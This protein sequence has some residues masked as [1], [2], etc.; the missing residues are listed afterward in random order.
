MVSALRDDGSRRMAE[1]NKERQNFPKGRT[2]VAEIAKAF[3]FGPYRLI[4][5]RRTLAADGR[6]VPIRGRAFDLL[7]ALV[8]RR[9][10]AVSKDELMD[11]VWPGRIVEKGNL[12]VHVAALR[13]F[14]GSGIIATLS[15]RGY[16]FVAP[17]A[18]VTV[19][20]P[21]QP[22]L[23]ASP[24][25]PP[26]AKMP[27]TTGTAPWPGD[28]PRPLTKLIGRDGDIDRVEARL[29]QGRL[30][31]VVGAGGVG[32]T[33]LALAA[34]DRAWHFYPDGVW[35]ADLGRVEDP[36]LVMATI[37]STLGIDTGG[38]EVLRAVVTWLAARRGLLVLD[39]CEHLLCAAADAT[40]A[41]LRSCP[42]I[43]V[44]AT[45]REPLRA[46]GEGLHR[47]QPL[48]AAAADIVVT[49]E[50]LGDYPAS[51][52][53]VE[54]ARAVVG[55]FVPGDADAREIMEICRRLDGIPLAIE[56]AAPTLQ[57][58]TLT[59]LRGRL[60]RHFGLLSAGRRTA[61]AR[62]QTL[63][64]TIGWSL[65]L[66]APAE[67]ALLLRLSVFAGTWT[68]ESATFVAG[69]ALGED[70]VCGL[71]AALVDKSLV[72]AD[73]GGVQARYRLLDSTRYYAAGR[74]SAPEMA[75][76]RSRLVQ[77][78]AKAYERAEADW[79]FMPD[80]DWFAL[81]APEIENLRAGL[82]WA[83]GPGGSERLGVELASQTEHVWGE[84]SLASELRDW[85]DLAISRIDETTPPEVGGRLWLGSCGWLAPRG[86]QAL[87]ASQQAAALLRVARSRIDL[88]RALWRQ[89]WQHIVT[90]N[91]AA[92]GPLL[93]EAE[94]L[95]RGGRESKALVS[96][97]RVRA[98]ARLRDGQPAAARIDLE[99]ALSIAQ[100]L[101]SPR[102]VALTLGSIAELHCGTGCIKKAIAVA[103]EALAS[104]GA[105]RARSAW[106]QHIGGAIAS[107]RLVEGDIERARPI[108]VERLPVAR[109]MRLPHEV[110]ANLERSALIAAI[111]GSFVAAGRLF[112]YVQSRHA[113]MGTV[114]SIGSQAVHD[115]LLAMLRQGL[116][117][118]QLERL[119]AQGAGL[120]EEEIVSEAFA[121]ALQS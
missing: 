19:E 82:A 12:T 21:Q 107:Y 105:V 68:S 106:V 76:A 120:E 73:L 14:L 4:P 90:G 79:P 74:L 34:A 78:L 115:R 112:G 20:G 98:V 10:R 43:T 55:E 45:S 1:A 91:L 92:A 23:G 56:L 5:D 64:A 53:F 31:T 35:L 63:E 49:A 86:A 116:D 67:R 71:T 38:G 59:E 37:A 11:L 94:D 66:L 95:L 119:V 2:D 111:Q 69:G 85:F 93:D 70:E 83:F 77:W 75:E 30:V 121:A 3:A 114:R 27:E 48:G 51:E 18:E 36:R 42:G 39:G 54:R 110:A 32:K 58:L 89:A 103:Q 26:D 25:G 15:G 44:L 108:V 88:G 6:E 101:R 29:H 22:E 97:L 87:H 113:Q 24:M 7:L 28:L 52:L 72:Q 99:E 46:E 17:V 13:K 102:D 60:G 81:Y 84:L 100:R 118:E 9:D 16:R 57:A 47:L 109:I 50:R 80:D 33:R 8:E 104:L 117:A 40:E 41:I 96:W 61:L 65:D 62:H